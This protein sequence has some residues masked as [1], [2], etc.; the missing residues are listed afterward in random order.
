MPTNQRK[1]IISLNQS[2]PLKI[3][4]NQLNPYE[5]MFKTFHFHDCFEISFITAGYGKYHML[6]TTYEL[7]PGDLIF[8]NHIEPHYLEVYD[9]PFEHIL[10]LFYPSL[11]S[12]LSNPFDYQ[13]IRP[14]LERNI[15]C[16]NKIEG[17]S[18]TITEMLGI[19][20]HLFLLSTEQ[21]TDLLLLKANLLILLSLIN[22]FFQ[23]KERLSP[24][25]SQNFARIEIAL[26]HIHHNYA[27]DL[28]LKELA[29]LVHVSLPYFSSLFK[30]TTGTN[31]T[32]YINKI[33]IHK[34]LDLLRNHDLKIIHI[35]FECGFNSTTS[36]NNAFKKFMGM[37][38]SEFREQSLLR[39]LLCQ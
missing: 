22:R 35:A 18:D 1:E 15:G 13:Y 17:T 5:D 9:Q 24:S 14:F 12:N 28:S 20:E 33:R 26:E 7:K 6:N 2:F 3:E 23:K 32:H 10:I 31:L 16:N 11:V 36:F 25:N 8:F 19:V 4:K 27:R 37:T 21:E 38:P 30:S 29:D 34:S 39:N